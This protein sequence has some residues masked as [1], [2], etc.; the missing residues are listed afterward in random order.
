MKKFRTPYNFDPKDAPA[1]SNFYVDADGV[2]RN[3]PS[4][5][6]PDQTV[7]I[8]EIVDRTRK[9]Q[10]I[11]GTMKAV[12]DSTDEFPDPRTMDYVERKQA[13][14]LADKQ[15]A[16]LKD[17]QDKRNAEKSAKKAKERADFELFQAHLKK[18]REAAQAA[19]LES[20]NTP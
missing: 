6:V 8:R 15:L 10:I 16:E 5:T 9:G 19:D 4:V 1:E 2:A 12:F 7:S 3:L 14:E 13:L 20:T 18:L 11:A 17:R